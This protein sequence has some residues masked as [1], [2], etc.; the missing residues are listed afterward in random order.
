MDIPS[1]SDTPA[2]NRRRSNRQRTLKGARVIYGNFSLS[3]DCLIRNMSETGARLKI[4]RSIGIPSEFYLLVPTE[5]RLCKARMTWQKG[6]EIGVEFLE[7]MRNPKL[8][9]DPRISRLIV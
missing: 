8:D 3:C 7:P 2:D 4:D 9:P 1:D 5:L 6:D